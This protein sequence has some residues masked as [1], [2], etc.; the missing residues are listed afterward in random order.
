MTCATV[1]SVPELVYLGV[2]AAARG[3]GVGALLMR[4]AHDAFVGELTHR[5]PNLRVR[6]IREG[7]EYDQGVGYLDDGTM[8]VVEG[9]RLRIARE[10]KVPKFVG[11]VGQR[12]FSAARA[13]AN[14]QRLL[15]VTER[16]VF[17]MAG[18]EIE[19]VEVAPG[20]DQ[21]HPGPAR[22]D[23]GRRVIGRSV[24]HDRGRPCQH[25]GSRCG[26]L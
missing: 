19:L 3:K 15:Y 1:A 16:A 22:L 23:D 4:A 25:P 24:V 21:T 2:G 6:V 8:V 7:R 18:E 10:G 13:R 17:R 11:E 20:I 14:G 12:S 5:F 9:G 26:P